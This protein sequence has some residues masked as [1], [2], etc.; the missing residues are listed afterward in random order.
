MVRAGGIEPPSQAW[1]AHILPMYYAR[2]C[3]MCEAKN[4]ILHYKHSFLFAL[5]QGS[6]Y[7]WSND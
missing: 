1:E 2:S 6:S 3:R 7:P 5:R 4:S